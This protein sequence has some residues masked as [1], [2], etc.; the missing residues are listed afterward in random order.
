MYGK[1]PDISV[2]PS[3]LYGDSAENS[4][5][6]KAFKEDCMQDGRLTTYLRGRTQLNPE[7]HILNY[8]RTAFRFK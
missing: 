8:K 6:L 2:N 1:L 5:R 3:Y 4:D 7:T